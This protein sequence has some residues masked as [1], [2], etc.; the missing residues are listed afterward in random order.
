MV[1]SEAA[2]QAVKF[3]FS[4]AADPQGAPRGSS[5]FHPFRSVVMVLFSNHPEL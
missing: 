2:P 4:L 3:L 1:L 5:L